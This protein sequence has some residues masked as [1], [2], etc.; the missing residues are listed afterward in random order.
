MPMLKWENKKLTIVISNKQCIRNADSFNILWNK[1]NI[2]LNFYALIAVLLATLFFGCCIH[3][4]IEESLS[5]NEIPKHIRD[6]DVNC[7]LTV[8]KIGEDSVAEI[9]FTNHSGQI[10]FMEKRHLFMNHKMEWAAFEVMRDGVKIPYRGRTITR[11]PPNRYDFYKLLPDTSFT[12]SVRIRDF[13]DIST[14]GQ[15]TIKYKAF[16]SSRPMRNVSFVIE[17]NIVKFKVE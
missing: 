6:M 13:Y 14:S 9:T 16:N 5:V 4:P 2:C 12:S 17:S 3:Q 15:Y 11:G 1:M 10:V 8:R 7:Q